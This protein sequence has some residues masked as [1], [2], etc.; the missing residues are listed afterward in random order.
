LKG[1]GTNFQILRDNCIYF[2]SDQL[3]RI[4]FH[5]NN[6]SSPLIPAVGEIISP[7]SRLIL[8]SLEL[9][10]VALFGQGL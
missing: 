5:E 4:K 10:N 1:P 3:A 2:V 6:V 8:Q 7:R 9:E